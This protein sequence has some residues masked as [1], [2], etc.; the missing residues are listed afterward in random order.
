[1]IDWPAI[2]TGIT[3]VAGALGIKELV[4]GLASKRNGF[5]KEE[6]ERYRLSLKENDEKD[7]HIDALLEDNRVIKEYAALLRRLLVEQ[8]VPYSMIPDWPK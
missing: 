4:K 8:G 1:M 7:A 3:A 5:A 6:K 2:I